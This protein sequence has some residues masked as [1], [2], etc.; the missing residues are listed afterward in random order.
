MFR[1]SNI[2]QYKVSNLENET[3]TPFAL[4]MRYEVANLIDWDSLINQ[5]S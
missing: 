1:L 5:D 3:N 4:G 2:I